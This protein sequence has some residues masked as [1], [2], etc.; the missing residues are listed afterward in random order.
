MQQNSHLYFAIYNTLQTDLQFIFIE[1][2]LNVYSIFLIIFY[3]DSISD[4]LQFQK[5][6]TI[7]TPTCRPPNNHPFLPSLSSYLHRGDIMKNHSCSRNRKPLYAINSSNDVIY[8]T[9]SNSAL[10]PGKYY[11]FISLPDSDLFCFF[12]VYPHHLTYKYHHS[13]PIK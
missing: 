6:F 9:Q 2:A 13:R 8:L 7:N 1:Y 4:A 3:S 5:S 10:K 12:G 11:L